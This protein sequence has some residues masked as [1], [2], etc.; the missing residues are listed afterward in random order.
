[1]RPIAKAVSGFALALALTA[2]ASCDAPQ[3]P[4]ANPANPTSASTLGAGTEPSAFGVATPS[5]ARITGGSIDS[6][7]SSALS[8]YLKNHRLPLVG[9]QV[10]QGGEA[11]QVILFGF[12]ATPQGQ[13][14]AESRTR[15]YLKDASVVIDNRIKINPELANSAPTMLE[16]QSQ[17]PASADDLDS[18]MGG[19]QAYQQNQT[20]DQLQYQNQGGSSASALS[21]LLPFIGI[22]VGSGGFGGGGFGSGGGFGTG[23]GSYGGYGYP[24]FP[25][26]APGG[27]GYGQPPPNFAPFP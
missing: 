11:R 10:V 13:L 26:A 18:S 19:V 8:E 6:G 9:A 3:N 22:L 16:H 12:V 25:P 20:P 24:S 23:Y 4:Y 21:A 14:D 17:P 15:K 27:F 7:E 2:L 5:K 1:M